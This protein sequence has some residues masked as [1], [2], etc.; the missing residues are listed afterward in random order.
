MIIRANVECP[1]E[2]TRQPDEPRDALRE[3]ANE[4]AAAVRG[5]SDVEGQVA[6]QGQ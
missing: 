5:V 3:L 4:I 6:A 2:A 1:H